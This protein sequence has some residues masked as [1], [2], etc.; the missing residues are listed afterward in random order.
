MSRIDYT[1]VSDAD[2][3]KLIQVHAEHLGKH[4]AAERKLMVK[5]DQR[6]SWI[7]LRAEEL[8]AAQS[9]QERRGR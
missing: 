7:Q 1:K 8:A 4:E 2:L 5:L 6:R 9:E 3:A